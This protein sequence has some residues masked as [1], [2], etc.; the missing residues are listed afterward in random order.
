MRRSNL[1]HINILSA[2]WANPRRR[3][4]RLWFA[5]T[6]T[7]LI[8]SGHLAE[9]WVGRFVVPLVFI[10]ISVASDTAFARGGP[11]HLFD[12]QRATPIFRSR[13]RSPTNPHSPPTIRS[14]SILARLRPGSARWK[15]RHRRQ[16][17]LPHAFAARALQDINGRRP[18]KMPR[19]A[20]IRI[21]RI[22][23]VALPNS[24]RKDAPGSRC[25]SS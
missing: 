10:A 22:L 11:L 23:I 1:I 15:W 9:V 5:A 6:A 2:M 17:A 7:R 21:E 25:P 12:S 8:I 4:V 13:Y 20:A 24:G 19:T 16:V 3:S 18:T 14:R